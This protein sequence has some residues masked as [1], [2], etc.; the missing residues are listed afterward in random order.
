MGTTAVALWVP[1]AAG[2]LGIVGALA[3]TAVTQRATRKRE[4]RRW[5]RERELDQVRYER[6]R[7][8]RQRERRTALYVDLAEYTQSEQSSLEAVT[9]EYGERRVQV[10]DLQHPDRL[11]ARVKLYATPQVRKSWIALVRAMELVRWEWSEGDVNQNEHHRWLDQD[12]PAVV[13]LDEAIKDMQSALSAAID[14]DT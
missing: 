7:L 3:G 8:A 11:T 1:L 9:D 13:R 4:D 14:E 10:P 12:N 5:E 6:E 2:V